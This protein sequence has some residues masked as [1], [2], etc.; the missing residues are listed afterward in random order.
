MKAMERAYLENEYVKKHFHSPVESWKEA[1]ELC[2][3]GLEYMIK[4]LQP[5]ADPSIKLNQIKYQLISLKTEVLSL[6]NQ[7]YKSG[8]I[9]KALEEADKHSKMV[10]KALIESMKR[11]NIFGYLI[12]QIQME[13]DF[14]WKVCYDTENP[15]FDKD[16]AV[17]DYSNTGNHELQQI[18]DQWSDAFGD[19]LGEDNVVCTTEGPKPQYCL[20]A[21]TVVQRW[22]SEVGDTMLSGT[23]TKNTGIS[24][25]ILQLMYNELLS[26]ARR[27]KLTDMIAERI[28]PVAALKHENTYDIKATV[29]THTINSFINTL[30]WDTVA[31]N[32][33][34][35]MKFPDGTEK[36]IFTEYEITSPKLQDIKLDIAFP[37]NA[38]L[39]QWIKGLQAC[40]KSNAEFKNGGPLPNEETNRKLGVIL[41]DIN[42][43][44]Q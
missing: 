8:D 39:M 4:Y 44:L 37:G 43:I 32:D 2:K 7:H 35:S 23:F 33:R 26:S 36:P 11:K 24:K 30:G 15:L 29:S 41:E 40:F 17:S 13:E 20:L 31:V 10:V 42:K 1:T 3:S 9:Q 6:L 19:I 22:E 34:P 18:S 27:V 5:K 21:E 16:R 14:A 28:K 12:Q 38:F 25:E